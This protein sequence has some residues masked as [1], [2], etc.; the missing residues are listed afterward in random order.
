M[1]KKFS[2][3][4]I[5]FLIGATIIW[6]GATWVLNTH[7]VSSLGFI[8]TMKNDTKESIHHFTQ[9]TKN[10][11]ISTALEALGFDYQKDYIS[12]EKS[13]SLTLSTP[14]NIEQ[15]VNNVKANMNTQLGAARAIGASSPTLPAIL[16][17]ASSP[18]ASSSALPLSTSTNMANSTGFKHLGIPFFYDPTQA[19]KNLNESTVLG[20]IQKESDKWTQACNISFDYKG[21]RETDYL[22]NNQVTARAEGVIKWGNLDGDAIGQAHEGTWQ[23]PA[24]GFIMVLKPDYFEQAQN[25]KFLNS[26][27]LHEMGHVIGLSHSKNP[28]SIMFWQQSERPQVLNDTDKNMCLYFRS[29]W[30]GMSTKEASDKYGLVVNEAVSEE[31]ENN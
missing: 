4:L 25:V 19:P 10:Q 14:Q 15:H 11:I 29:R 31:A 26:A 16:P 9:S 23:G 6:W 1:F 24:T 13:A 12:P 18:I 2:I 8:Q 21:D 22:D 27:I 5:K 28:Q 3:F 30:E 20:L 7:F 17:I